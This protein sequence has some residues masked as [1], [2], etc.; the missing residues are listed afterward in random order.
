MS[1]EAPKAHTEK[2]SPMSNAFS[3]PPAS[4]A[5]AMNSSASPIT[6]AQPQWYPRQNA[7][8]RCFGFAGRF[9]S[10]IPKHTQRNASDPMKTPAAPK[11]IA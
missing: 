10:R 8:D 1:H 6:P 11:W 3:G 5:T 2:A 4:A 7:G 9:P